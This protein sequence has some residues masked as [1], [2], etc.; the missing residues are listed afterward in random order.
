M[1]IHGF[2]INTATG[3]KTTI[4]L[5]I[6]TA[7]PYLFIVKGQRSCKAFYLGLCLLVAKFIAILQAM[8]TMNK[9]CHMYI[10]NAKRSAYPF[11]LF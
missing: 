3:K 7:E 1:N 10:N 2:G 4:V 6:L 11:H 9:T 8:L 5:S